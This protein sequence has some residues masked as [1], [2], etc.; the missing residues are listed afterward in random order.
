MSKLYIKCKECGKEVEMEKLGKKG[1]VIT[2][3]H[4]VYCPKC[5]IYL[6]LKLKKEKNKCIS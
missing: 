1:Y 5:V 2:R 4:N 3:H 6:Y